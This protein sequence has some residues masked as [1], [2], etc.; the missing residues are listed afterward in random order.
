MSGFLCRC[1]SL[2][3]TQ[4]ETYTETEKGI[5][6][7]RGTGVFQAEGTACAKTL[8]GVRGHAEWVKAEAESGLGI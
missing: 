7:H 6:T 2:S 8:Q 5:E 1:V 3:Y 4:R